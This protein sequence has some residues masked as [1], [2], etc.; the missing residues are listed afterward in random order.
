M[1]FIHIVV[2]LR[3]RLLVVILDLPSPFWEFFVL[4]DLS[5]H[6]IIKNA[7]LNIS[8]AKIRTGP[9]ILAFGNSHGYN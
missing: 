3:S 6:Q 5:A 8:K 1:I 4:W 9:V 2:F 7:E